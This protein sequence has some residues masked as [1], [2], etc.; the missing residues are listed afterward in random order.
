MTKKKHLQPS[1]FKQV[2]AA[3]G[4]EDK[5]ALQQQQYIATI[6]KWFNACRAL[7]DCCD[8]EISV[9]FWSL[10]A[11]VSIISVVIF[12]DNQKLIRILTLRR[13]FS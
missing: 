9:C 3:S 5:Y 11:R 1:R 12:S 10:Q 6:R 13:L 8:F 7:K 4:Q 2:R